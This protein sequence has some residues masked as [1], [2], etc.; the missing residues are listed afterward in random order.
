VDHW[1]DERMTVSNTGEAQYASQDESADYSFEER[2]DRVAQALDDIR[3]EDGVEY[4]HRDMA[5]QLAAVEDAFEDVYEALDEN[6]ALWEDNKG[7]LDEVAD[8]VADAEATVEQYVAREQERMEEQKELLLKAQG[9]WENYQQIQDEFGEIKYNGV[10]ESGPGAFVV[11]VNG[12]ADEYRRHVKDMDG[13]AWGQKGRTDLRVDDPDLAQLIYDTLGNHSNDGAIVIGD[14]ETGRETFLPQTV[15]IPDAAVSLNAYPT[16]GGTKH[17]AAVDAVY[18]E[19]C[20]SDGEEMVR[21]ALVLS[22]TDGKVRMFRRGERLG[23]VPYDVLDPLFDDGPVDVARLMFVEETGDA[24]NEEIR[25]YRHEDDT[26]KSEQASIAAEQVYN[27]VTPD[28]VDGDDLVLRETSQ[29][30]ELWEQDVTTFEY[31]ADNPSR[32]SPF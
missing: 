9:L 25:L 28:Q 17:E 3:Y 7:L 12:E 23:D 15:K 30:I 21:A 16:E 29:G 2:V 13:P 6:Y 19:V 22:S 18:D 32:G 14:D 31:D 27:C 8:Q 24:G 20:D 26:A 1:G 10:T 11:A 5:R 4:E